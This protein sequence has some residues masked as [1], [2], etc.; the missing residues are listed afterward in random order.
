MEDSKKKSRRSVQP[1]QWS[2]I[3]PPNYTHGW[4]C[5]S[6]TRTAECKYQL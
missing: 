5:H 1:V 4:F 3:P 2:P 6:H